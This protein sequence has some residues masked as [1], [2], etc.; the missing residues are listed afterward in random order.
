MIRKTMCAAILGALLTS[1][2]YADTHAVVVTFDRMPKMGEEVR[3]LK[4]GVDCFTTEITKSHIRCVASDGR[5]TW[6]LYANN[7]VM[8]EEVTA[9]EAK[10][11]AQREAQQVQLP[12]VPTPVFTSDADVIRQHMQ[13]RLEEIAQ[14][15]LMS[16]SNSSDVLNKRN[17]VRQQILA[18]EKAVDR[19]ISQLP[20]DE[21]ARSRLL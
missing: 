14:A 7:E 4:S 9:I 2:A 16:E 3:D 17:A 10:A 6:L 11:K 1:T 5:N 18:R 8:H 21:Q 12:T 19:E 15:S 20:Q 13:L